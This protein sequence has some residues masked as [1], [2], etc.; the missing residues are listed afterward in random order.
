V[1]FVLQAHAQL[2]L[3]LLVRHPEVRR[4]GVHLQEVRHP[5]VRRLGVHPLGV[6]H[7]EVRPQEVHQ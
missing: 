6:H 1:L 7:P 4:L 3:L 2:Q 5:E